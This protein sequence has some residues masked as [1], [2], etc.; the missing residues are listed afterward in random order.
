MLTSND[1]KYENCS[2]QN[3][4]Y[5]VFK[6]GVKK[7]LTS[8]IFKLLIILIVVREWREWTGSAGN[9]RGDALRVETVWIR[10]IHFIDISHFPMSS[11]VRGWACEQMNERSGAR[12]RSE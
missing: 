6:I 3:H 1:H 2:M 8:E 4:K 12:E 9:R 7:D 5:F 11:G 10:R